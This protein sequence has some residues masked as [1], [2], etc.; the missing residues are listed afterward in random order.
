MNDFFSKFYLDSLSFEKFGTEHNLVLIFCLIFAIY[1]IYAGLKKW[2]DE[3]RRKYALILSGVMI[4]FQLAKPF[5]KLYLGKFDPSEDLPLHLCN[6]MPIAM[7]IAYYLQNRFI[8]AMFLFWVIAGSSQSLFTPTIKE[9]LPHYEALRYWI[10]HAGIVLLVFY[11]SIVY[12]WK[13][14][15]KDVLW[16]DLA[17]HIA[18]AI[19]YPINVALGSNYFY[20]NGKPDGETFY[21]LLPE[22]PWYILHLEWIMLL[23]FGGVY[24][25]FKGI[26]KITQ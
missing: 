17:M 24:L 22:W 16:S 14:H 4:F 6:L 26:E 3:K 23:L 20:L 9:V 10:V 5:I 15:W 11:G 7:F 12:Q 19:I 21:S 13:L 1:F 8:W 2:D 25:V 18:A